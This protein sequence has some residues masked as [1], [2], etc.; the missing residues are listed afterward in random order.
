MK[1]SSNP[2]GRPRIIVLT[3]PSG[4]GKTSIAKALLKRIDGLRFS[5]SATTRAAR[6]N[7]QDGIDY[8]FLT[9]EAFE[10]AVAQKAFAEY[11]EVYPGKWYGT[12]YAEI[13]RATPEEPILLDIDVHG[14]LRVK[15]KYGS[16]V[17]AI[18]VAPPS[19]A[20]LTERLR[21]R[22]TETE[23]ALA[24]RLDRVRYELSYA[25]RF[26]VR[27]VNDDLKRAS[28]EVTRLTNQ[29]LGRVV[30]E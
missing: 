6:G 19:L 26:D 30:S 13:D 14:A 21:A 12:P 4:A 9:R 16:D 7:E 23:D 24:I 28:D 25:D 22:G 3:A 5:V 18:F 2:A 1:T 20:V 8:H 29:F 15:E 10:D 27:V 11:E 17:Q